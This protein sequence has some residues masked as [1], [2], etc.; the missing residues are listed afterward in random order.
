MYVIKETFLL[1]SAHNAL[2]EIKLQKP[3]LNKIV[4]IKI[5]SKRGFWVKIDMGGFKL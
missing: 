3:K 2:S 4:D 1:I 5:M